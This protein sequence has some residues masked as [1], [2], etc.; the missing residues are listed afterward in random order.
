MEQ[1]VETGGR[2]RSVA[3]RVQCV[4]CRGLEIISVDCGHLEQG[5]ADE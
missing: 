5:K 2:V 3:Y 4:L 1:M